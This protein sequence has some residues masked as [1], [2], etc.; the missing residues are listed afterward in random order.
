MNNPTNPESLL[1]LILQE[2]QTVYPKLTGEVILLK[3]HYLNEFSKNENSVKIVFD[4]I[5]FKI[6]YI[7]D[8]VE[9]LTGYPTEKFYTFNMLFVL[10]LF[11]FD[12]FSFI[13][14]WLKWAISIY[15]KLGHFYNSKQVI[16]GVK[17]KHADGH[18][19]R[20]MFRYSAIEMTENGLVKIAAISVDDITHMI[21]GD[22]YWGRL[23]RFDEKNKTTDIHHFVSKNK[24]DIA[25]D[26]ITDSEKV[27]LK[28]TALGKGSKE[29]A[30][31]LVKSSHTIDNHRRNMIAKTGAANTASLIHIFKM[32]GII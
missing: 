20:L 32:G 16:C 9:S 7:S 30:K 18:T 23:E 5:N 12:H 28:L 6:L 27:I 4:H 2:Q 29:I 3:E 13:Y 1:S 11:T 24:T 8:N 10:G 14:V 21:K 19:L 25:H 26:L 31:I 15:R 22:S 17:M